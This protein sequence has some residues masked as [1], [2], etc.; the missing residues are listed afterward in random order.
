MM[1]NMPKRQRWLILLA[2][3]GLLLLGLD[4]IVL[5][6]LGDV[7]QA[8]SAEIQQLKGSVASGRNIIARGAH[9]RQVWAEIQS[10]ALPR[11]QAQSEYEVL[12]AFENCG[13]DQRH[14][15]RIDQAP[16]EARR[17]RRLL[18]AGVPAGCHRHPA[19]AEPVPV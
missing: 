9:L 5:T 18:P 14:R 15:T 16:L 3:A 17:D 19:G 12:S 1:T 10:G 7:W 13:P 2:G 4:R 6:P 11:D 8:H